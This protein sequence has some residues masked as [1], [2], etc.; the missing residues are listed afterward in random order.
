MRSIITGCC[1]T[2]GVA[3]FLVSQQPEP[4][5]PGHQPR[6]YARG[7]NGCVDLGRGGVCVQGVIEVAKSEDYHGPLCF[8]GPVDQEWMVDCDTRQEV[9]I[10]P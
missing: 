6:E 10:K 7:P 8:Y 1:L 9:R 5:A 4:Q 2:V 3:L